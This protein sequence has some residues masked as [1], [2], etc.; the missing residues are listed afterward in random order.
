MVLK[1]EEILRKCLVG[2]TCVWQQWARGRW[3]QEAVEEEEVEEEGV[4]EEGVEE[5]V[6]EE[7]WREFELVIMLC[8]CRRAGAGTRVWYR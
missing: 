2:K 6:E 4:E 5:E 8:W 3:K 1:W 7:R